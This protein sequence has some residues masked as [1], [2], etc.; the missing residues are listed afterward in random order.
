MRY[1]AH[2]FDYSRKHSHLFS[3]MVHAAFPFIGYSQTTHLK[4]CWFKLCLLYVTA[5]YE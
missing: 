1:Y 2:S 4:G 3:K 5:L